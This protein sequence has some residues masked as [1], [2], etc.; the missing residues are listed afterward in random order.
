MFEDL[1]K[2][3]GKLEGL[4]AIVQ[5]EVEP[6][7]DLELTA[8]MLEKWGVDLFP[9]VNEL[10]QVHFGRAIME[11]AAETIRAEIAKSDAMKAAIA[12]IRREASDL[13]NCHI[14]T[15]NLARDAIRRLRAFIDEKLTA[16]ADVAKRDAE[17]FALAANQCH[18]GYGT[19]GGDHRCK[20]QDR[21]AELEKALAPF[22]KIV[23][24]SCY[25]EDG[26][27]GEGYI[28]ILLDSSTI[29]DMPDEPEFTGEDL[30]RARALL[31]KPLR[32][33]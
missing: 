33:T 23:P 10:G 7:G 27:E 28:A 20:Y 14:E 17:A 25:S 12:E 2:A 22:A 3:I 6:K 30:A 29:S 19:E 26:S 18:N 32:T 15:P 8:V 16:Q 24:S 1:D 4:S 13:L 21:I 9:E 5:P 31:L 11:S